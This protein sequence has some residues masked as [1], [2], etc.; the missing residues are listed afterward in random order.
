MHDVTLFL[1]FAAAPCRVLLELPELLV[2]L[3]HVDPQDLR[4]LPVPPV[5]RVTL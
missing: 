4:V 3:D 1:L 5:P 2:S